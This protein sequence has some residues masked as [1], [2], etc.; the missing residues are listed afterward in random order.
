M[1][2]QETGEISMHSFISADELVWKSYSWHKST[3]FEPENGTE[4]ST[5]E[6]SFDTGEGYK[7]FSES[8]GVS[9][10]A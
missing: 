1:F 3:L 5:K 8:T 6:D 7:S 9:D 4:T 2:I 10:V